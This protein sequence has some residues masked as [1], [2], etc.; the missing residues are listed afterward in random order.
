MMK[1]L[2]SLIAPLLILAVIAA[3]VLVIAFWK[4]EPEPVEI[5]KVNA[6]EGKEEELVLENE[7]LRFVMDS[8][9]TCFTLEDK[10]SGQVWRSNPEGVGEDSLALNTEKQKLQSTLLLTY[11]TIN[12]VDTL[13]D[14]YTYSMSNGI[15]DIEQGDDYIKVFY[16]VGDMD[17]E[18]VI[19]PV[20]LEE[21]MDALLQKM[22]KGGMMLVE[23]YYKKYDINNLGKKDNKE[24]LLANYPILETEVAY[25]LR[26][27]T[28][29]NVKVKFEKFFEEAGYTYEDYLAD[30]E[31]DMTSTVSEKPVFNVNM[32]YRLDGDDL[33]VEV[34]MGEIEYKEDYPLLYLSVLP[35]FGAGGTQDKGFML[36]PEGGGALIDF[37]NGK[38]AQNSYYA[39]VYGW[40]MA[41]GRKAL[42]HE[43]RTYFNVFGVSKEDG[44][45]LCILE[46]GA[47]YAAVQADISGRNNSYNYVNAVYSIAHREQYDVA[48]KYNGEMY[49]YQEELPQE[50]LVS[51]YRFIDSGSYVDMAQA[52]RGYLAQRYGE[53]FA[54]KQDTQA[55]AVV[56][57]LG[58][59]D[60]TKQ[61]LGVPVSK[62]LKLTS[63]AEA[64]EILKEIRGEGMENLYVKLT[65]WMNG[66]V[67]QKILKHVKPISE[68]G[69]KKKLQN[70]ISYMEENGI[71][72]YLDGITD[73]ANDS[74]LF[75]GFLTTTDAARL[76]SKEVVELYPF[77]TVSYVDLEGTDAYYLL[78]GEKVL[79]MAKNLTAEAQ[80]L[81][82]GVSFQN[83]GSELSSDFDEDEPMS[84]MAQLKQQE[85]LLKEVRASGQGIMTNM[86]NDYAAAYTDMVSNMDLSGSEYTILDRA[87]PFY[88]MAVHGYVNYTGESLNLTQDYEE[89]LLLSAQYGAGL[90]FTLMEET[91]FALQKTLYTEY[92]GAGYDAWHDRMIEIYT[93][94]NAELGHTF[95]QKMTDHEWLADKVSCTAYED[96]TKVYVNYGY[97]DYTTE[98]GDIVPARDYKT[99]R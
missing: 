55:P 77:S 34:P 53:N 17:K 44:S 29:D 85:A 97:Q 13:Y 28:K 27:A 90:S 7:R 11:S 18:Y 41:Q 20:I 19:P 50:T 80:K 9:T 47:P 15:Y 62:P 24:E 33:V 38:V 36:V 67:Q 87:V 73:Y 37:N 52:Y 84:R 96:G 48:D 26:S 75:D 65:G 46:D 31:M 70:L 78:K 30:K 89:E 1:K 10:E 2:K 35:Y 40:D 83:I 98:D 16:T 71:R 76:V 72:L 39:N 82:G 59:V 74:N 8:A 86:G 69:G 49:V 92:F 51:R 12:G 79:Q 93:R 54:P 23:Q 56:E 61:I 4:E 68:L 58:A 6:Y 21:K 60:K 3:G 14:N 91:A 81:G 95:S 45:F 66:G 88:Q 43:T 63:Y 5:V 25:V 42:V 64:E 22:D 99:V 32:V 94:Y 57:I